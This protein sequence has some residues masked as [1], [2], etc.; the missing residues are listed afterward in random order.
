MIVL[1]TD[2]G[3]QGPYVGQMKAV[4]HQQ[5]P[6]QTL[7]D[8]AHDAPVFDARAAGYLLTAWG[9]DFPEDTVFLCVIDPGVGTDK[10]K[11][12]I[13]R[14]DQ[15][16]YTG[17]DN[18]LFHRLAMTARDLQAWE[19]LWRPKHLSQSFHGRDLFAP[20]AATLSQGQMPDT[21]EIPT[22]HWRQCGWPVQD[23][24]C[25]YIDHFG[26]LI[27]GVDASELNIDKILRL[28][29]HDIPHADTFGNVQEGTAFWY[30]NSS[31]L[32][33]I[34]INRGNAAEELQAAPGDQF[35]T[36]N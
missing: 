10:R 5:A 34:A 21:A 33:E 20:V 4:L 32:V 2:F 26:N 7:I 19:I 17:P 18:G 14:A 24:R 9:R 1:Y 3:L 13:V 11:P 12:V 29:G 6:D 30:E 15:R 16:W 23:Y 27:T 31:G 8:L 22:D 36:L 35:S 25:L 28:N